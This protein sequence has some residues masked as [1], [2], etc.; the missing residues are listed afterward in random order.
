MWAHYDVGF[1]CLS[2][3][4]GLLP[5]MRN[6]TRRQCRA[7]AR[8]GATQETKGSRIFVPKLM[9]PV[10]SA[11]ASTQTPVVICPASIN[12]S[13]STAPKHTWPLDVGAS[14]QNSSGVLV[15]GPI[16][17]AE[18]GPSSGRP[19]QTAPGNQPAH[20]SATR[21]AIA[22]LL[23][24]HPNEETVVCLLDG[25]LRVF[26]VG[27]TGVQS[28]A[29]PNNFPFALRMPEIVSAK[30]QKK[31]FFIAWLDPLIHS[32]SMTLQLAR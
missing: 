20:A 14:G 4:V 28:R 25:F 7:P 11:S 10:G 31:L 12:T 19:K 27:F 22:R 30:L 23:V 24:T 8:A 15:P 1:R 17:H 26:K 2:H 9:S 18:G 3:T 6:C 5:C 16:V 29:C 32:P 13:V 21:G